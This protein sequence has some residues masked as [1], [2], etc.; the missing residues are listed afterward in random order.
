MRD[1][2][3]KERNLRKAALKTMQESNNRLQNMSKEEQKKQKEAQEKKLAAELKKIKHERKIQKEA[4][5][6]G[7]TRWNVQAVEFDWLFDDDFGKK[8]LVS[9]ANT[10]D[11]EVFS[12]EIVQNIVMFM[13]KFYRR[14]IAKWIMIPFLFYFITYIIYAT[15]IKKGKDE[16]DLKW[17][18]YGRTDLAFCIILLIW[19]VY[20]IYIEFRQMIYYKIKYFTNFWNLIDICS[21]ILNM[22]WV[23]SDLCGLNTTKHIPVLAC[24]VLIMWL[25]LVYFGRMLLSTAWMVRMMIGTVIDLR[26]F[27]FVFYLMMIG[28]SNVFFII[29][30]VDS[31][32]F[33]G[34]T[35][36]KA[37]QYTYQ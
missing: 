19:F 17:G 2:R 35:F 12:V 9:L 24:S 20:F 21:L 28:F 8:F 33:T 10:N 25:K 14:A 32:Q 26:W 13:W 22:F 18:D 27:I 34:G 30:R 29:S 23:I 36:G 11:I 31:P 15:W 1:L 3:R 37:I 5:K 16:S 7:L 4:G 6:V